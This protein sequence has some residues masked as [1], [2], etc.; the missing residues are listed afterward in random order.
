M[1][2]EELYHRLHARMWRDRLREE[3]R[4]EEA[5]RELWPRALGVLAVEQRG[6]LAT[7]VGLEEVDP[8]ERGRHSPDFQGLWEEMTMVRRSV[9]GATW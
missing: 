2:R 9:P 8:V 4:F 6:E 3:P 1:D 5:V 7:R